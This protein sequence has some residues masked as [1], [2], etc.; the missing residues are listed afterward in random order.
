MTSTVQVDSHGEG[1]TAHPTSVHPLIRAEYRACRPDPAQLRHRGGPCDVRWPLERSYDGLPSFGHGRS[2]AVLPAL[3]RDAPWTGLRN[4]VRLPPTEPQTRTMFT[5]STAGTDE[6]QKATGNRRK[7]K[8]ENLSTQAI[9]P[10]QRLAQ[11]LL[12]A[13]RSSSAASYSTV[14][15]FFRRRRRFFSAGCATHSFVS[16]SKTSGVS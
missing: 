1:S 10:R 4:S 15:T 12:V 3:R 14:A 16:A 2:Q 13:Q 6:P 8:R 11:R 9:H 5:L 7:K